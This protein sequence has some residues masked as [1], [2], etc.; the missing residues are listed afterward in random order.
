MRQA[1]CTRVMIVGWALALAGGAAAQTAPKPA[2]ASKPLIPLKLDVVINEYAGAKKIT[3]LPYSLY[4]HSNQ[5][6]NSSLRMGL[7]VPIGMGGTQ[8]TYQNVGTSIDSQVSSIDIDTYEVDL[9][10]NWSSVYSPPSASA[11][12]GTGTQI[13]HDPNRPIF[14]NFSTDL[15]LLMRD[16]QTVESTMATDPISGHVI[17]VDTTLHVMK[18]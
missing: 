13:S 11:E 7:R 3:T 12:E 17:K 1:I 8:Y 4:V 5:R 9:S 2:E 6:G 14:S 15:K 16:G 10:V 18:E